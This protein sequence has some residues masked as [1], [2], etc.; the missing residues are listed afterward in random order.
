MKNQNLKNPLLAALTG[1]AAILAASPALAQEANSSASAPEEIETVTV[2]GSR[3]QRNDY[4]SDSPVVTVNAAAMSET[5]STAVEHLLNQLPQFVPS[6]TTTSNNPANGGQANIDLRGLGTQRNLVLLNGR[7]LPASNSNGTVDV[8]IVPAAL[9]ENIEVVTGGA[10]AVYGSDAIAGVTNFTLKKD[11]EGVAIDSGYAKTAESD[12]AEWSSSLTVGSNFAEDRGNA[13]FSFQYTERDAIYQGARDFSRIAYDVRKDGL[14]PQGSSFILESRINRDPANP[15][16]Q[17]AIDSVFGRY[18]SA[19]GSVASTQNLGS[20]P[21]GSLFTLGTGQPGT[22]VNF[23]GDTSDPTFDDSGFS[24]NFAPPNALQLPVKRWNLAGFANLQLNDQVEGYVQTFFTTYDT[25]STLAPVPA[26]DFDVPVTNPFI[27]DDLAELLASRDDPNATFSF[28]QRMQGVGPRET[29]DEYDVYQ[30]LGG[31]RGKLGQDY[32]WDVY[33]ASARMTDTSFL[34]NDVSSGRLQ[35]LLDA[36]DGGESE[37]A[38]GY[39]PFAGP[40][41]LSAACADHV[42]AYFTNRTTLDS[43]IAEATFGG[44]AFSLPAGDAKFSVGASWREESF[45]F[46][47]DLAVASGDLE[48]FLQQDP[49]KG[50]F[51]VTDLFGEFYLPLLKDK[52]FAKD[53]GFT[54]G[55]RVS[56]HSLAGSSNSYKLEGN[57]QMLDT[58]RLRASYQRAVRAPSIAELFSPENE[59]NPPLLE[60]PCDNNSAARNFGANADAAHGGNGAIRTLCISQG[61]AAGDVD[62]YTFT[63]GQVPTRG[64]GNPALSEERADTVTFGVVF[65]FEHV[66]AS[67][68]YYDIKLNDAIFSV[69]A[70]EVVLLCYGF[71]GNNPDLDPNDPACRAI[72]RA[73]TLDGKAANGEPSVPS[74]GTDNVSN[75][76]TA[77]VDVQVD[78]AVDLGAAGKLDLN[79]LGNWLQKWEIAY[80]PGLP[81]IDYR[82]TIGDNVASAFPDYKLLL[83]AHWQLRDFGAGLRVQYLPQMTNKYASYDPF[84]TVGV[85]SITYL[86]ANASWRLRDS[87]E[88]RAGVENLTDEQPPLYTAAVQMNT[89]PST[90]DVLGRRY[91]LRANMKF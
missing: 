12:G 72:N 7:R 38:G 20:N 39:N 63:N 37:C 70:G 30:F 91:Y 53:V 29:R 25:Q 88:L 86:D 81:V 60:D 78:W 16:T 18:G 10:S 73:T 23:R 45:N 82:G 28:R 69:P 55:A 89:D 9:I 35:E 85:P 32:N 79:L 43:S 74:Q 59:N 5:G 75:L 49:L 27:P 65:D 54:L 36:P 47:P 56:D 52:R 34:N 80:L 90:Y 31:L 58:M 4:V 87:L 64:G 6:I 15:F 13:V 3:I 1:A 84:T 24:Y 71:S 46:R 66:R 67:V 8:N 26:G 19:P 11:F 62:T 48:G 41:G 22:V 17:G 61:I 14:F 68:D 33:V 21:D 42:R 83:N 76:R 77:G 51:N 57:W 44:K 40:A 2:T 50:A